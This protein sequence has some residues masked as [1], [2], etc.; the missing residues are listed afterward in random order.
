M[1]FTETK[2]GFWRRGVR[3]DQAGPVAPGRKLWKAAVCRIAF[4]VLGR[5]FQA[6][7]GHDADIQREIGVWPEGFTVEMNVLPAGPRLVLEKVAGKLRRR[8]AHRGGSDLKIN[9]K[10]LESACMVMTPRLGAAPAFAQRRMSVEG[11]LADAMIFTRC[12]NIMLAYL[13]PRTVCRR[14]VKRVP[15]MPLK[16]QLI[17]IRVHLLG[18]PFG[19]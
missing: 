19:I 15:P 8:T 3:R 2:T 1:A 9:F 10:N 16:K 6:A 17:R 14:L 13:Y 7:A 5:A 11:N 18:I 12:L 4:L